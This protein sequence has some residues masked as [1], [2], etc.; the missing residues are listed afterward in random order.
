MTMPT[1]IPLASA[2]AAESFGER[3]AIED[4]ALRMTYRELRV[5]S[6]RAAAALIAAGIEP[7][8][9]VAIWAPNRSEWIVL[10]L[11]TALAGATLVP[12][13]TRFKAD[14]A[15]YLLEKSRAKILFTAREFLGARYLE[16][17]RA[18]HGGAGGSRPIAGLPNLQRAVLL[19]ELSEFLA[20]GADVAESGLRE[21]E[22]R[23]S[24]D[25]ISDIMFTSGTTGRPKGVA[26]SHA[27]NLRAIA[28]W[29]DCV[30]LRADD[31]YLIVSPFFHAFGWKAGVLACLLT[32]ATI[33]PHTVFDAAQVLSRLQRESISVLPGPP[34]LYQSLLAHPQLKAAELPRLR[35]AVTGAAVV[36]LELVERMKSELGFETIVTGYGLTE[37]CGFATMCRQGDDLRTIATTSGRAIEGVEVRVVDAAGT[38]VQPGT[39]GEVVVRGYNVMQ[40]Y[41]EAPGE[42][43]EVIDAA[44]F[45]HT[46]D[47]GVMDAA[48]NLRITDR[49]KDMYIAGGFNC[50]PA[51]IERVIAT[52]PG[53]AQVAVI[54]IP[55]ARLGEVGMAFIVPRNG[56]LVAENSQW[57][58]PLE[59]FCRERMANYKVPRRFALIAELPLN[60]SGKVLKGRLR[61]NVGPDPA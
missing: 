43:R 10:A 50:Y 8:D 18:A 29:C 41:F 16:Q 23:V 13:N 54:G 42:T 36:P 12:I 56:Q 59:A 53:V 39:P 45:L 28:A 51:E 9:R 7:A 37:C 3:I 24:G 46:G 14:E 27:Q 48:G 30:G 21:R 31:R 49:L 58:E 1:T 5:A 6:Q 60:A 33:L 25:T 40:G 4:G 44:G 2:R 35:L 57:Y 52:H 19:E 32:G 38:P 11:G 34:T 15:G 20:G 61:A 55:D 26:T 17:L 22:S 47:V